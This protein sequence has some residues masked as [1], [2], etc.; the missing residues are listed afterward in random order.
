MITLLITLAATIAMQQPPPAAQA[1]VA[2]ID[3]FHTVS[4]T[5]AC[6]SDASPDAMPGLRAAGFLSVVSFREDGEPG[7][8]LAASEHAA[9]AAG[10]RFVSIPFNRDAPDP[11]AVERFLEVIAAPETAPAFIYCRTGERAA[12]MWLIKRVK[13]D[14]W[15]PERALAEAEALGLSRPELKAFALAFVGAPLE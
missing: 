9:R 2:G 10:L 15:T 8:S 12:M 7:Y 6:G 11:R 13:Q 3:A 1:P 5:I 4:T 14:G